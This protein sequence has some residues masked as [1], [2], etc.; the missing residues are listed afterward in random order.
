MKIATTKQMQI[1]G[2]LTDEIRSGRYAP[3]ATFPSEIALT[4]RFKVSRTTVTLV[5]KELENRGLVSRAQG[6]GTFITK[7]AASRKIGLIVPGVAYSEFFS[8]LVSEISRL[9][10]KEDRTL[11]FG[12]ISS[13]NPEIRVSQAKKFAASIVREGVAGVLY[14]PLEFVS[15]TEKCNREIVTIFTDAGIPVVLIDCDIV[16][17]PKRSGYDLVGIN[18]ESA[19]WR[20]AELMIAKGAKNIHFL[21][22]SDRSPNMKKRVNGVM[23]AV[24]AHWKNPVRWTGDH[25]IDASPDDVET[26]RR[27]IRKHRPDAIICGTDITA[28]MLKRTLEVIGVKVP[29]E[30]KLAGVDDTK[31]AI[32][33]TPQLTTIHQPCGRIAETAFYRL[34]RRIENPALPPMEFLMDAELV[35]RAST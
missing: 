8:S 12:D 29:K 34:L 27:H 2:V 6:R 5:M 17:P 31:A 10:Q 24:M 18:N 21:M 32:I 15:D 35:E 20:L 14:Q 25:V 23:A 13:K 22:H 11:L 9:A 7:H 3:L 4:R 26:I 1:L 33:M 28:A 30:I 19:G 16:K